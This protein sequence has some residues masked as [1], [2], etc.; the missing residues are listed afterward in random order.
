MSEVAALPAETDVLLV[1]AGIMSA[2]LGTLLKTLAPSVRVTVVEALDRPAIESSDAWNNAG[3]GHAALCELNYTAEQPDGTIAIDRAI[4]INEQFQH[5]RQFWASLV[6]RGLLADPKQFINRIPHMSFVHGAEAVDFLRRRFAA[7]QVSPLFRSMQ[8]SDD[9]AKVREWIPLMMNSRDA[10]EPVAATRS[11]EG[12]DLNFGALTRLLLGLL[13]EQGSGIY[14]R[15]KVTDLTRLPDNRWYVEVEN[16]ATKKRTRITTRFVFLGAGGGALPLLQQSGIPEGRGY[17]GFPVSGQWL[18]CTNRDVIEQHAAKVYGK[19]A[20]G[21]PPMSV[22]HLDTRVIDGKRELLFG[23]FAGFTTKFLKT[24]SF[25]DLP[26]SIGTGNLISMLG[27]GATNLELTKYLIGQVMQ[28]QEDRINALREF[29]PTARGEDWVLEIAGQRVQIIKPDPKAGGKL[30][31]GTEIVRSADGSLA[32][33][34]GASPGASTAVSIM[35]E[36]IAK[37]LPVLSATESSADRI[38][39]LVPSYGR[40]MN[41]EPE[42]LTQMTAETSRLL[43]LA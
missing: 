31:F 8:F 41:T 9:A 25:L 36:L 3:T 17:G 2:T 10:S 26:G 15:H 34:L 19:P 7:M 6:E 18:R 20:L 30:E 43:Q 1:G 27:A 5:S 24:G 35:L 11:E 39:D 12:T 37:G 21:A 42:L 23:P 29:V 14:T 4:K 16:L 13:Y 40:S 22:P 32:A 33:L 38:R 28:S